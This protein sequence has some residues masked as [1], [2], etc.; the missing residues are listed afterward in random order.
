MLAISEDVGSCW[1][2]LGKKLKLLDTILR[3]IDS[4]YYLSREKAMEMLKAWMKEEADN[5]TVKS[6]AN[7]L[8]EI[9]KGDIVKK[10]NGM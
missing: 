5:A 8:D 10:H 6:L 3:K 1:K 7:A 9:G 4:H 2:D